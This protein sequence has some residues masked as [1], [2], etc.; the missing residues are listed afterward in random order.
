MFFSATNN[1]E[2]H[3]PT[4]N[5]SFDEYCSYVS[6]TFTVAQGKELT[7][8]LTL[9]PWTR[10][11]GDGSDD[12]KVW[13]IIDSLDVHVDGEQILDNDG[14]GAFFVVNRSNGL[15]TVQ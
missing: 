14:T 10:H 6:N 3:G 8:T 9:N 1:N 12:L 15:Y 11:D 4:G 13:L 2:I 7:C 5:H